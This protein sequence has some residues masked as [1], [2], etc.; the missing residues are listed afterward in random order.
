VYEKHSLVRALHKR[1]HSFLS[2]NASVHLVSG[3]FFVT[4]AG[5][6]QGGGA[7]T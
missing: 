7:Q 1:L 4:P 2:R 5:S 6:T 3:Q